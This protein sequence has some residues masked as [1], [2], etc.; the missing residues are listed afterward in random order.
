MPK[1][2]SLLLLPSPPSKIDKTSLAATYKPSLEAVLDTLKSSPT[3]TELQ[4]ALPFPS[5]HGRLDSPRAQLWPSAQ[6]LLADTYSLLCSICAKNN[7]DVDTSTA[8]SVDSRIILLDYNG[9]PSPSDLPP[10]SQNS[11]PI[12]DLATLATSRKSWDLIFTLDGE[13]GQLLLQTYI[14]LA[15]HHQPSLAGH[16][17]TVD[18]GIV[19]KSADP[20]PP[21]SP[22]SSSGGERKP[23][24]IVAVG[25]TFDHLHAGHKLLL[26]ATALIL[27]PSP[28]SPRRLIVGITGDKLLQSKKHVELLESWRERQNSVVLFLLSILSF[29]TTSSLPV[30]TREVYEPVPNGRCIFTFLHAANLTIECVE[31]QDPFGPTITEEDVTALV[32]SGET[33]GGGQAVNEKREEKGWG[34]LEVFEVDVLDGGEGDGDGGD[35]EF[36]SKISSSGI[37]KRIAEM[38]AKGPSL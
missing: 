38:K 3:S 31:I 23:H 34:A 15:N 29:P 5:L 32:V 16:V 4:I 2:L 26:T 13:E 36:G 6:R 22:S 10:R 18:R 27:Q 19:I 17:V 24:H 12:I 14:D 33:R 30:E 28:S 1:S 7:I 21:I 37:R 11:G 9:S 35:G 25:G 8:G 20:E